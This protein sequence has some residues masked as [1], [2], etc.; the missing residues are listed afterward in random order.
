MME[1]NRRKTSEILIEN[2]F[3]YWTDIASMAGGFVDCAAIQ[4][5]CSVGR[6]F[7]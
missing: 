3:E 6:K 5:N 1:N 4:V 2:C 7:E